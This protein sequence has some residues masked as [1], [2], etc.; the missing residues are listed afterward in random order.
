MLVG[1]F[2]DAMGGYNE[3]EFERMK[4]LSELVRTSSTLLWNTQVEVQ[5]RLQPYELWPFSWDKFTEVK[6][7]KISD[8]ERK[9]RQAKQ[10]DFL[11]H[12][13]QDK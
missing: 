4:S 6:I 9:L 11:L 12:N 1:D 7:E 10:D 2:L 8:E 3:G 5:E 13:S